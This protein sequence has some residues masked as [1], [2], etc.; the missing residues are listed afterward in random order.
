MLAR[1]SHESRRRPGCR[2]T[3]RSGSAAGLFGRR[4][5]AQW[6]P[7]RR[8]RAADVALHLTHEVLHLGLRVPFRIARS[9]H[10]AGHV[11][12]TV[13]IELRDD[14][15]PDVTGIG[16]GYP[17]R[18]YG[19]T[20]DTMAAVFPFLLQAIGEFEPTRESL[21]AAGGRMATAVAHHGG[22]KCAL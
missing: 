3:I 20:V 11:V 2:S 5:R 12:T 16:E 8:P 6:S 14:R 21:V 22:A 10:D 13:I 15:W 17:D 1:R 19:D 4:S 9:D 18:F 7:S